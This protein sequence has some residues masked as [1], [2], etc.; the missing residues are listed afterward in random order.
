MTVYTAYSSPTG[1]LSQLHGE[2]V[3]PAMPFPIPSSMTISASPRMNA[4][5]GTG[6]PYTYSWSITSGTAVINS[7]ANTIQCNISATV[8]NHSQV[9]GG[10]RS[11]VSDGVSS[12]TFN[13]TYT[14][15]YA[16]G[17]VP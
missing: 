7:G 15:Y 9:S 13:S 14:L 16:G 2:Y 12:S 5:G 10:I 4:S 17:P 3:D 1:F 8:Q 11:V 6:G